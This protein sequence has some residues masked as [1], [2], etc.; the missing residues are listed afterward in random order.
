MTDDKDVTGEL[1]L[2]RL[3]KV[4]EVAHFLSMSES[5]VYQR[6]SDGFLPSLNIGGALRFDPIEIKAW[7]RGRRSSRAA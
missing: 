1:D 3:W 6:A 5:W 2:D 7:I 4:G